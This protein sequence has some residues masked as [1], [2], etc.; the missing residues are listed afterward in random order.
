MRTTCPAHF[1]LLDFIIQ[2]NS[3][4][5]GNFYR[6]LEKQMPYIIMIISLFFSKPTPWRKAPLQKLIF[7]QSTNL[8]PFMGSEGSLPCS[9]QPATGFC[10]EPDASNPQLP[11]PFPQDP[12]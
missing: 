3:E 7:T 9:Q 8:P 4:E 5:E 1:T 2:I 12:F 11:T 6:I 10:S